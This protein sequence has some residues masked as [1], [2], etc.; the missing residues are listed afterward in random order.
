[1]DGLPQ[2]FLFVLTRIAVLDLYFVVLH[3]QLDFASIGILIKGSIDRT[4]RVLL[5]ILGFRLASSSKS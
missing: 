4:V 3:V 5:E 1:M 2:S